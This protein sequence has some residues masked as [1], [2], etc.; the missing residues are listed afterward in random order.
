MT[1]RLLKQALNRRDLA[2]S[3]TAKYLPAADWTKSVIEIIL[4]V[5]AS[6]GGIKALRLQHPW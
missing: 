4:G 2:K 6:M 5:G 3:I 1:E